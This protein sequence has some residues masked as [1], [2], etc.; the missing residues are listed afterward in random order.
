MNRTRRLALAGS[1]LTLA[2]ALP[3]LAEKPDPEFMQNV[4]PPELVMRHASEIGLSKQQRKAITK[5]VSDTQAQ[6]LE[7][8][9]DM[10][11]AAKELARLLG[12]EKVDL[13]PT[14]A[15][16]TRVMELEVQVKRAHM[17]LLIESKN[18]LDPGQQRT[19]RRLRE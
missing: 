5:A 1:V 17:R 9:W 3:A 7:I 4:F 15:I 10:A 8:S 19:L 13:E 11:E 6:T 14:L 12:E 16:A 18:Q 2:I